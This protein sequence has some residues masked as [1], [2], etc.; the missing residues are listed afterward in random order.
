MGDKIEDQCCQDLTTPYMTFVW[1]EDEN[2]L[3]GNAGDLPWS[4]PAD[5][6]FFKETTIDGVVVMGRKTYE[7]I[8][9][10]P[11]KDRINIVLTNQLDYEA[12]GAIVCHS[13]ED[14][15]DY[16]QEKQLNKPIH[17][18]GGVSIF[19]LF[20]DE[21]NILYRTIIEES[22]VGDT[23]M[24]E[25]DY[26]YFRVIDVTEGIVDEKNVY[27]HRFFVYERKKLMDLFN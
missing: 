26:K 20:K 3:I 22:F 2:G 8:P 12:D 4:L 21:V 18:I 19:N 6:K 10:R 5:M 24:P 15:L 23:Y 9:K 14:V 16:I 13:K 17:I 1:A 27:P 25:M 7:S 11:L